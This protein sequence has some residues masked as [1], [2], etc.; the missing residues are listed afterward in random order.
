M[1][2][3]WNDFIVFVEKKSKLDKNMSTL[4]SISNLN[5]NIPL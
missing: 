2:Y 1:F 4:E 3:K 5:I